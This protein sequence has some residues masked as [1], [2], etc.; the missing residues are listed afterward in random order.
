MEGK[1]CTRCGEFKLASAFGI[2]R[3]TRKDGSVTE[4]LKSR[5]NPCKTLT[6]KER[7]NAS[8]EAKQKH[9]KLIAEARKRRLAA[10]TPEEMGTL[11][12]RHVEWGRAWRAANPD[13]V[14]EMKRRHRE[15]HADYIKAKKAA[16]A[17]TPHG[18]MLDS[19]RHKRYF[20]KN[21]ETINA[22]HK[23]RIE[24]L[25]DSYVVSL[26]RLPLELRGDVPQGLIAAKRELVKLKRELE[27]R[28]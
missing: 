20:E 14:F 7:I 18:K 17:R 10:K 5:C 4:A 24:D 28:K 21:R 12:K 22:K 25:C 26:F 16:D 27:N 2:K 1:T 8:P 3:W 13:K 15:K 19:A 9:S 11:R 6:E 23:G